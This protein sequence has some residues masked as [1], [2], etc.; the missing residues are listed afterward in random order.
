MRT[1]FLVI[2]LLSCSAGTA[3]S[4]T[5]WGSLYSSYVSGDLWWA[6]YTWGINMDGQADNT[7]VVCTKS[8]CVVTVAT[9]SGVIPSA[10]GTCDSGGVCNA[11]SVIGKDQRPWISVRRGTTWEEAYKAF[12]AKYGTSGSVVASVLPSNLVPP[13]SHPTWGVLCVG[14]ISLPGGGTTPSYL[15]PS[16]TC[17][18][19]SPPSVKCELDIDP[20]VDMGVIRTGQNN[21]LVDSARLHVS[22]TSTA[23]I[24]AALARANLTLAGMPLQMTING[25]RITTTMRDVYSGKSK[26]LPVTFRLTGNVTRSGKFQVSVPVL[27]NY[28]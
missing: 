4:S 16:T 20:V 12:A 1:I 26:S 8:Q 28:H 15:A 19:V 2:I 14:F 17:G 25:V 21:V 22:C 13:E 18:H 3:V 27:L 9:R 24:S 11:E 7:P 23:T 10:P 5:S 6:S